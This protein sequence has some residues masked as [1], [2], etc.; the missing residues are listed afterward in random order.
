MS[1]L[2][3]FGISL[4]RKLIESFDRHI[5]A[6]G[7]QSRSEALRD[8]IR[9]ELLRKTTA[10]GGLVAGA[11]VMTYD[12]H[13]R[14]LVNRLIDIQHDFH[15]LIISTQHVHLDHENCLEVIA[16]K[17]NAPEIEKLSSA[18]KVL[19]GVKHLDLSLSSAD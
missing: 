7:Y 16:V 10:E 12:H 17:G 11:I 6:Q 1:D 4:E 2:Y 5:K 9:E 3:R 8:L 14:D 15:D 18:L 19:V 13:K